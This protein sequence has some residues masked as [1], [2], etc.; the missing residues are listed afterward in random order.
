MPL[1]SIQ[2]LSPTAALGLWHLTEG[3]ADL[4]AQLPPAYRPLLPATATEV[5][6]TQWLAGRA[7][8]QTLLEALGHPD[9]PASAVL[10][11]DADGRPWLAGAAPGAVASLSH[12]G[13]WVA[14]LLAPHGRVGVDVELVRDKAQRLAR[15]YLSDQELLAAAAAGPAHYSLLWSAK[16]TLY[17]LAARRGIIFREQLL[18][19]GFAPAAHGEIPATLW[20]DGRSTHHRIQYIQPAPDYVLTY[21]Y[22]PFGTT[23]Y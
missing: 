4:W 23:Q 8:I 2:H 6:Q 11:N 22:E 16:E 15:K 20:L 1:H 5:R 10:R 7:L 18:L 9:L 3:P 21:S 17:K 12:S 13:S 19:E 14:A